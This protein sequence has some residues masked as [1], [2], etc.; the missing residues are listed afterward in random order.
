MFD[1]DEHPRLNEVETMAGD[2][3][4]VLA[5]SS[6]CLELWFVIHFEDHEAHIERADA[7]RRSAQLLQS[8]KALSQEALIALEARLDDARARARRLDRKHSGDGSPAWTNPS[9]GA[10][11][12]V[13]SIRTG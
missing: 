10:W 13:D 11:R 6:P 1:V 8:E 2:N 5:V 9:S 4:V 7:Q 12:L 3:G